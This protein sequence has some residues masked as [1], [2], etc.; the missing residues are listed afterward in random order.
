M[1]T[2]S[3]GMS[4]VSVL[5]AGMTFISWLDQLSGRMPSAQHFCIFTALKKIAH[6]QILRQRL[7]P[8]AE[9]FRSRRSEADLG[10]R[11]RS[12]R[13]RRRRSKS[14]SDPKTLQSHK[15]VIRFRIDERTSFEI[16]T[17]MT[18]F[19]YASVCG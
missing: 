19:T 17:M 10:N 5:G 2:S 11:R 9:N 16:E 14:N 1:F 8:I 7:T 12:R 15:I 18:D 13:R 4:V 3:N 6:F